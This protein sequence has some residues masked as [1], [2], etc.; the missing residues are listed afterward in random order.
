MAKYKVF[1][2]V[3]VTMVCSQVRPVYGSEKNNQ[4]PDNINNFNNMESSRHWMSVLRYQLQNTL[5]ITAFVP[6]LYYTNLFKKSSLQM[7]WCFPNF[8]NTK[9]PIT[10]NTANLIRIKKMILCGY[11]QIIR[12]TKKEYNVWK[13]VTGTV[14]VIQLKFLVFQ[15]DTSSNQC[16]NSS[17]LVILEKINYKW[18]QAID[19][20]YCGFQ[21][22][23]ISTLSS[24]YGAVSLREIN[25]RNPCNITFLY[26]S[27]DNTTGQ[28]YNKH[29][30]QQYIYMSLNSDT[31]LYRGQLQHMYDWLIKVDV[32]FQLIFTKLEICCF[33]GRLQIFDG[34]EKLYLLTQRNTIK[35]ETLSELLNVTTNYFTGYVDLQAQDLYRN[36]VYVKL[37]ALSYD[38]GRVKITHIRENRVITVNS[39]NAMLHA[40]F[41][42]PRKVG[43]YPN[44]SFIIRAFHGYTGANCYYGGYLIGNSFV[45][46]SQTIT[47]E[48]GPYCNDSYPMHP[49]VGSNGPKYVVLGS[50]HYYLLFFA[51]GPFYNID[52]D[53]VVKRSECEGL[54]EPVHLCSSSATRMSEESLM[55]DQSSKFRRYVRG[56]NFQLFCFIRLNKYRNR[57]CFAIQFFKISGC[58][59]LQT[60]S[61]NNMVEE[62]YTLSE[63]MSIH[64]R[65]VKTDLYNTTPHFTRDSYAMLRLTRF[66]LISSTLT[67]LGNDDLKTE[68]M[69]KEVGSMNL[70]L[71]NKLLNFGGVISLRI[72]DMSK[73]YKCFNSTNSTNVHWIDKSQVN[74][75]F[76]NLDILNSCGS[77][78]YVEKNVYAIKFL[79]STTSGYNEPF[80]TNVVFLTNCAEK[81]DMLTVIA[82]AGTI[83]HAVKIIRNDLYIDMHQ[84]SFG[85]IYE[86]RTNC[87]A[88][89]QYRLG[90]IPLHSVLGS[91]RDSR[92]ILVMFRAT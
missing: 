52:L 27:L 22:P 51:Y 37:L 75:T 16:R 76:Y 66:N 41:K 86:K 39:H 78:V 9:T 63:P 80:Y 90:K 71:V 10:D 45:T 85:I 29:E 70:Y 13:T 61:Y 57:R 36:L 50:F 49:I 38:K 6:R 67:V 65:I 55:V 1:L 2:V 21:K 81:M 48:Q 69:M 3:F 62:E 12:G 25:V 28:L 18:K 77:V 42:L 53:I 89:F 40:V 32:G 35:D 26:T 17:A 58:I 87:S 15:V 20:I 34:I 4:S 56:S 47:Y 30:K 88:I 7:K 79:F 91:F 19:V 83:C 73:S 5:Q 11:A 64:F 84:R 23:W 60:A 44:V 33:H 68:F 24:N 46:G 8:N 92:F 74:R 54:F 59:L 82:A 72:D 43:L 31:L 14:F